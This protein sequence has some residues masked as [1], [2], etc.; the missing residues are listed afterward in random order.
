M[1]TDLLHTLLILIIHSIL[2]RNKTFKKFHI[3]HN[4]PKY[5]VVLKAVL[6]NKILFERL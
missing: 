4:N 5:E 2:D 3:K 1:T 6:H